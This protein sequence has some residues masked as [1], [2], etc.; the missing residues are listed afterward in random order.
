M[1]NAIARILTAARVGV[2]PDVDRSNRGQ[3][4]AIRAT[5]PANL[6]RP[7]AG[8]AYDY[9]AARRRLQ[10]DEHS[11]RRNRVTVV[12]N[13]RAAVWSRNVVALKPDDRNNAT[14]DEKE[15]RKPMVN[16]SNGL[17]PGAR[18]Q[19]ETVTNSEKKAG[20]T[21]PVGKASHRKPPTNEQNTSKG[22]WNSRPVV[23]RRRSFPANENRTQTKRRSPTAADVTAA[24]PVT[25][26]SPSNLGNNLLGASKT[27]T[28]AGETR[29]TPNKT[30]TTIGRPAV[31]RPTKRNEKNTDESPVGKP[32]KRKPMAN[33]QNT[34]KGFRDSRPVLSRRSYFP[35]NENRT[36]AKRRSPAAV[37]VTAMDPVTKKTTLDRGKNLHGAS[38][39][40]T[41]AA[42]TQFTPSKT[43]TTIGRPAVTRPA[44]RNEKSADESSIGKPLKRK[45]SANKALKNVT[46]EANHKK[47]TRKRLKPDVAQRE[48]AVKPSEPPTGADARKEKE[49]QNFRPRTKYVRD[50]FRDRTPKSAVL[51]PDRM[52]AANGSRH[53]AESGL[54]EPW[55]RR[56]GVRENERE[57][58]EAVKNSGPG[59]SLR[60]TDGVLQEEDSTKNERTADVGGVKRQL[61]DNGSSSRPSDARLE[62]FE[63]DNREPGR[64]PLVNLDDRESKPVDRLYDETVPAN[65][66]Q[67][68]Y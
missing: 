12:V 27:A 34:N 67:G 51:D 25:I 17:R 9:C 1:A 42:E 24:N 16:R 41:T 57:T 10:D 13:P 48:V 35:V 14:A 4:A 19:A 33:E 50:E 44:K 56:V 3:I 11:K 52:D 36:Q 18:T 8:K 2:L 59:K 39:T 21:L 31:T 15:V 38:K 23:S 26:K 7:D 63:P 45:A 30:N 32:L 60:T 58:A 47:L 53:G 46:F 28:T 65:D 61:K 49:I 37:D 40:A 20:G 64:E 22:F 29:F 68:G 55:H 66:L 43:D 62:T 6:A 54:V 5:N